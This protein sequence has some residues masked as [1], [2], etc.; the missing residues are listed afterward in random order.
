MMPLAPA[1]PPPRGFSLTAAPWRYAWG[2]LVSGP[3]THCFSHQ[4][5]ELVAV[6]LEARG[7]ARCRSHSLR[8]VL[9]GFPLGLASWK[10]VMGAVMM[11]WSFGA[12][13]REDAARH[14]LSHATG[15]ARH[16]GGASGGVVLQ[17]HQPVADIAFSAAAIAA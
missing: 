8:A 11:G 6:A 3:D 12:A 2:C 14:R 16:H 17:H 13:G 9:V 1:R 15:R 4:V 5:S 10:P 7:H